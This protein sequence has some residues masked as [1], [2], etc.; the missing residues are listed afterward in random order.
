MGECM[1]YLKARFPKGTLTKKKSKIFKFFE[2]NQEESEDVDSGWAYDTN[3]EELTNRLCMEKDE[4]S[5]MAS[6]SHMA[7]WTHIAESLKG[8]GAE[9]VIWGTE[10]DG[11]YSL[12]S[13][14]FEDHE[15]IV[16]DILKRK[17]L[18]PSLLG[19]NDELDALIA[20][21]LKE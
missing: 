6:V 13:L 3:G 2:K 15:R 9:K 1:Y 4:L 12:D 19:I 16:Q 17:T 21:K 14:Q 7:D 5:Y 10:E 11:C 18:L 20:D 8:F